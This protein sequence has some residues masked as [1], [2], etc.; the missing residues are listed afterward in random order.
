MATAI[1]AAALVVAWLAPPTAPL[2]VWPLLVIVP[3]WF[4]LARLGP[5]IDTAGR[6]GLAVVG[7]VALS[8][9]LVY[10]L[11]ELTGGYTHGTLFLAAAL[12]ATPLPAEDDEAAAEMQ[13][14]SAVSSLS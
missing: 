13:K 4:L 7:S 12:L 9:H 5:R 8:T 14:A 1:V 2:L 11:S 10:W 6:L 3:G